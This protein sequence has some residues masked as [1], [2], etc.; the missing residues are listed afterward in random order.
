MRSELINDIFSVESEAER[1]VSE[2]RQKARDMTDDAQRAG[3]ESVRAAV[4]EAREERSRIVSEAQK[5]SVDRIA[6][7]QAEMDRND[8]SDEEIDACADAIA[9]RMVEI[10]CRS[11]LEEY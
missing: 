7:F 11:Q 4:E 8:P 10:L 2:A 5:N 9:E 6:A 3:Q 1:I